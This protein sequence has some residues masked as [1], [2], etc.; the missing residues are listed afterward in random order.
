MLLA[1]GIII[2]V[3]A[4]ILWELIDI[5]KILEDKANE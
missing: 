5:R 3:L 4:F 1:V 2:W